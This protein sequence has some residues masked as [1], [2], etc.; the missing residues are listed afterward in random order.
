MEIRLTLDAESGSLRAPGTSAVPQTVMKKSLVFKNSTIHLAS[1]KASRRAIPRPTL[2]FPMKKNPLFLAAFLTAATSANLSAQI[3]HWDSNGNLTGG[4]GVT[5]TGTWGA[6]TFWNPDSGGLGGAA[7]TAWVAGRPAVFSAGGDATGAWTLSVS[8]TQVASSVLVEEGNITVGSGVIDTSASTFTIGTGAGS[9][10]RVNIATSA[11]L[12]SAGKVVLDGGTLFQTNTGN[13]GSF[14]SA[15]KGLEITANG[16]TVGY[17]DGN[18]ANAFSSIYSGT[19]TGTGGTTANGGVGTLT[20]TGPDEFRYQGLGLPNTTHAKL[21]VSQGLFRLG[22]N[23][24]VADERGFGA[25]P[26]AFLADA[27]T[28]QSGGLIGTSFGATLHVNRGITLGSGGGAINTSGAGLT[29]PGAIT[30]AGTLGKNTTG[31]LNLRG[32]SDYTGAT[33]ISAGVLQ[34]GSANALGSTAGNTQVAASSEVQFEGTLAGSVTTPEPFQIAGAGVSGTTGAINVTNTANAT[35]AGPVTLSADATL[36]VSGSSTATYSNPSAITAPLNHHLTLQGGGITTGGG[37]TIAGV[38]ALGTG[39]LTKLQ[40]GQWTLTAANTYTGTTTIGAGILQLGN[41]LSGNDGTIAGLSIVDNATLAFNRFGS[42]GYAGTI[43]GTGGVTK[44]GPGTQTL[45]GAN[46]YAGV[47]KAGAGV[48]SVGTIGNGGVASGNMG[49]AS[50]AATN[51]VFDGGTLRYTGASDSTDRNFTINT[52]KTATFDI[53]ANELTLTGAAIAT[54]GT[55]TKIGAGTL[56]LGGANAYT[57]LTQIDLGTLRLAAGERIADGSNL[58]LNGGTFDS[59]GFNETLGTLDADA[60][61]ILD[62]GSGTSALAFAD[63]DAQTWAGSLIVI[64]WTAGL[65]TF[66]VGLDGTGFDTQLALIQFADYGN[67]PA[68]IDADGFITPLLIPEPSSA[69]LCALGG[70]GLLSRFRRRA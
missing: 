58:R 38:I 14:I 15:T 39:G 10:A 70:L 35:M 64:N 21:V 60:A 54:D 29:I 6:S 27:I 16:G 24:S 7:T 67:V 33:L 20:K 46:T 45:S 34:V 4:A 41:G 1:A 22:F 30:G 48:L 12:N 43:S 32:N 63:S 49:S 44:L 3:L 57:G 31:T 53:A 65:D 59:G 2:A 23:S 28:L 17:D 61:S 18:V 11:R 55:L 19:I 8:G 56:T 62:F 40:G 36:T 69:L 5:P 25:V 13:A 50:N 42:T 26:T 37:G 51:L 52:G 47:T 9:T 66:R 68:Q